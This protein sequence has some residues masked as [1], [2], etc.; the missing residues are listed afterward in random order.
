MTQGQFSVSV[1][2]F[3]LRFVRDESD[4]RLKLQQRWDTTA[5]V[6]GRW[7]VTHD[8]RFVGVEDA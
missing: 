5:F 4:G 1:P 8:W 6:E 3:Y 7:S 2:T